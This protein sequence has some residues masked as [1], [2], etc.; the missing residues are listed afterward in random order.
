MALTA[1]DR[2]GNEQL[3]QLLDALASRPLV[4][5]YRGAAAVKMTHDVVAARYPATLN[6]ARSNARTSRSPRTE[7]PAGI[8]QRQ[9]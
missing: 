5:G 1:Y 8:R 4:N 2:L 7:G 9:P 3:L 6:A